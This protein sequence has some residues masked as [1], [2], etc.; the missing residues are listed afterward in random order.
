[1]PMIRSALHAFSLHLRKARVMIGMSAVKMY[2]W[3]IQI[4]IAKIAL[5]ALHGQTE[6]EK[7]RE[8]I[9]VYE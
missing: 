8:G 3:K 9:E 7:V 5:G 2:G 6:T 1:M 4:A